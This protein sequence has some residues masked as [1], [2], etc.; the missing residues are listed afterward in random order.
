MGQYMTVQ[1]V[2][3]SGYARSGK[4]LARL[5]LESRGYARIAL[6]EEIRKALYILN[7][8]VADSKRLVEAVN[9]YGWDKAKTAF[10]E[11]RRLLQN[12]G[13]EVGRESW[14]EEFWLNLAFRKVPEN[15]RIVVPDVRFPNEADYIRA[16]GGQ[17][18]RVN[19]PK[20]HPLNAHESETA[21]DDYSFDHVIVNGSTPDKFDAKIAEIL[22]T[23]LR[24]TVPVAGSFDLYP[25]EEIVDY[26]EIVDAIEIKKGLE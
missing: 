12:F 9:D 10:P 1:I 7:P 5:S 24:F 11:I 16:R 25:I 3:I 22:N 4:D 19:N 20:F 8:L 21:L 17:V 13:T 18:W 2:G 15:S 26:S 6:A 23:D 14:D